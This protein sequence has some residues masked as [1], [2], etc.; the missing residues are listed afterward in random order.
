MLY[1]TT[2]AS[3]FTVDAPDVFAGDFNAEETE[4]SITLIL[5]PMNDTTRELLYEVNLDGVSSLPSSELTISRPFID[6]ATE[7]NS[8]VNTFPVND[9]VKKID[10]IMRRDPLSENPN[11][12]IRPANAVELIGTRPANA[13]RSSGEQGSDT[14]T[15]EEQMK[16]GVFEAKAAIWPSDHF[17]L[18]VDLQVFRKRPSS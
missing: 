7:T 8:S 12:F 1:F 4:S 15:L 17:G 10:F 2:V 13:E 6:I 18:V 5:Q 14:M 16:L 9:P 11:L 3:D